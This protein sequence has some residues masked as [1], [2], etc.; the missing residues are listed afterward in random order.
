MPKWIDL[1]EK[2]KEIG[3]ELIELQQERDAINQ[4]VLNLEKKK[5]IHENKIERLKEQVEA[6]KARRKELEPEF[7]AIRD[8]LT[9]AGHN[10][11]VL[12]K[13]EIWKK[14]TISQKRT[15][16]IPLQTPSSI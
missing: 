14:R 16:L 5:A 13:V 4:E 9:G 2:I 6:Y 7:F 15:S 12:E 3:S 8:E 10:I 11:S 1:N